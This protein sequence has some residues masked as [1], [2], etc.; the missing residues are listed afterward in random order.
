M[1]LSRKLLVAFT[2]A[3][4]AAAPV[5]AAPVDR[6]T[7]TAE[8]ANSFGGTGLIFI[9]AAIAVAVLAV[10]AFERGNDDPVSP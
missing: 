1:N 8:D 7:Q 10:V 3:T 5:A 9:I 6:S 4:L 2:G